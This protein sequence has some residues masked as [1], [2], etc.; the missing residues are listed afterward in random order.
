MASL[1]AETADATRYRAVVYQPTRVSSADGQVTDTLTQAGE[2]LVAIESARTQEQSQD[3]VVAVPGRRRLS[4]WRSGLADSVRL[5][6]VIYLVEFAEYVAID[7]VE[8]DQWRVAWEGTTRDT[9]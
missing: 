8:R 9:L 6:W 4:T 5:D 3:G 2:L 7:A 1:A